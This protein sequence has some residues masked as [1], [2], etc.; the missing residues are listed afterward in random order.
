MDNPK[1]HGWFCQLVCPSYSN[2]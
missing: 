2:Y 1:E